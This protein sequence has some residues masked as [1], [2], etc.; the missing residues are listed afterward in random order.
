MSLA[1][2]VAL[3]HA[4]LM[5]LTLAQSSPNLPQSLRD[6]AVQTAQQAISQA[7]V[8]ISNGSAGTAQANSQTTVPS[9]QAASSMT[10]ACSVSASPNPASSGQTVTLN[11]TSQ[12]AVSAQWVSDTSGKDNVAVPAGIPGTSGAATVVASVIGNPT[13]TL[14]VVSANGSSNTCTATFSVPS[15]YPSVAGMVGTTATIDQASLNTSS[16][17]PTIT[18]TATTDGVYVSISTAGGTGVSGSSYIPVVNGHWSYAIPQTLSAGTYVVK[19]LGPATPGTG[20]LVISAPN[21]P[22]PTC[23]LTASPNS[24]SLGSQFSVSWTSQNATYATFV[25]DTS[26]KDA[27]VVPTDKFASSGST[28]LTASVTGSPIVTLQVGGPS[29][30][31]TCA[32]AITVSQ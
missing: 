11:W 6:Q 12:N 22:S 32:A 7:T 5:L 1:S 19:V 20:T 23:S 4:A 18:G 13:V 17:N 31:G 21:T 2:V 10:P 8:A 25:P 27:I 14:R 26:G 28:S 29:G 24:V 15:P 3:L 16:M 9:A 30:I